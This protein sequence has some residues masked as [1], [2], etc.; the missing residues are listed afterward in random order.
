VIKVDWE[1]IAQM[2]GWIGLLVT[3]FTGIVTGIRALIRGPKE[4]K[5]IEVEVQDRITAMAERWLK[6]A[7][8]RLLSTEAKSRAAEERATA[9]EQ[10]VSELMPR[11]QELERNLFSALHTIGDIWPWGLNGGGKPEPVLPAWI[12][13]W[14]HAQNKGS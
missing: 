2:I 4:D 8:E 14:L 11:V 13:E 7:D 9:A 10:K 12:L 6:E 3:A 5:A 1:G